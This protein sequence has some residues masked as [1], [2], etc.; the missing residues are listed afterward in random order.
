MGPPQA[1]TVIRE[2]FAMGVDRG[3]L[4]S[5]RRFGGADVLVT[6]HT[7]AQG[8]NNVIKL[9]I[10]IVISSTDIHYVCW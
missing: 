3:A 5:D 10:S 9:R 1:M 6:S 2:A 4:L 8:I 7:I